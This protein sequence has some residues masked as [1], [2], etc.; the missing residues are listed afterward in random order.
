M[1]EGYDPLRRRIGD[2]MT[3]VHIHT[4][5]CGTSSRIPASSRQNACYGGN[6]ALHD[7]R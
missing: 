2:G 6:T 4:T 5:D 3:Y 7:E 1:S